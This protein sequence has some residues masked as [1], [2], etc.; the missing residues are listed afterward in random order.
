MFIQSTE[1]NNFKG[2]QSN[3]NKLHFKIPNGNPGS[4][5]NILIGENNC[6][7]STFFEAINFLKE[8]SKKDSTT[9]IN[10][11]TTEKEFFVEIIFTGNISETINNYSQPN[12]VAVFTSHILADNTLKVR[13]T[14]ST[15]ENDEAKEKIKKIGLWHSESNEF[16]N[17]TGIDAPFKKLYD[18]NFI[19]ADTNAE[20]EAKFGASTLCG[21]LLKEISE[22][23]L[24]SK[25]HKRFSRIFHRIFNNPKS[26]LRSDLLAIES[27]VNT[28]VSEQFGN[29]NI[30]FTFDELG[31]DSFFKSTKIVIDDGVEVPMTEKGHGLQRAVALAL[32]QVY[33]NIVSTKDITKPEKPFFLFIDEPELCLHPLAQSKLLDSLIEI[34]KTKQIFLTTHSPFFLKSK[35][36]SNFGIYIFKKENNKNNA[37][38]ITINGV[39]NKHPTFNEIIFNAYN[40]PTEDF[41]DELF[42]HLQNLISA[43]NITQVDEYLSTQGI[44]RNKQWTREDSVGK[45]YQPENRT[46]QYFI[47][48]KTHHPENKKMQ[49]S[50]YSTDELKSSIEMMI[51]IING[52]QLQQQPQ[53]IA[54]AATTA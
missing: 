1:L 27:N 4:G 49:S 5:L 19:W 47:R 20:D 11:N 3:D 54:G 37:K 18:N 44:P 8:S 26:Q 28:Y 32:L 38:E 9:L 2:F 35:Y 23:H 36:L 17:P 21:Y 46:I 25:D 48:N 24:Q 30:K 45:T 22:S 12:K 41:H 53:A 42:G 51:S 50:Y 29:A 40:L 43:T 52:I 16:L 39:L 10:K 34:S 7:K 13:R 6:G 31:V 33:A 14:A 15:L